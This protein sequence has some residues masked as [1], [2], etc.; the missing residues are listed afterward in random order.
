M[1]KRLKPGGQCR[2]KADF[3][4]HPLRQHTASHGQRPGPEE[5]RRLVRSDGRDLHWT[6][7]API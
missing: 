4:L 2:Q 1:M 6:A 7:R 3:R 5:A